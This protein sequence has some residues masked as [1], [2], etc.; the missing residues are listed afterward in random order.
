M[1]HF[2]LM[3]YNFLLQDL[4][5]QAYEV[6]CQEAPAG[7]GQQ[8]PQRPFAEVSRRQRTRL[9]G[10]QKKQAHGDALLGTTF[11]S[12]VLLPSLGSSRRGFSISTLRRGARNAAAEKKIGEARFFGDRK[13]GREERAGW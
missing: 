1:E 8:H 13:V 10:F 3:V 4:Q 11:P 7:S 2:V 5:K 9:R 12:A 6:G